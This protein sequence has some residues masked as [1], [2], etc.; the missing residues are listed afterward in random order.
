MSKVEK[1]NENS[2]VKVFCYRYIW[3]MED[4]ELCVKYVTGPQ[5]EHALFQKKIK[6]NVNIKSCLRE[7]INE[8]DF[9]LIGFT[10]PVKELKG[11]EKK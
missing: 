1:I 11:D 10:E 8:V 7:Y 5:E 4:D 9:A 3:Q 2:T 6:E